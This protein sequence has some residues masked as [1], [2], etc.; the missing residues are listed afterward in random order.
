MGCDVSDIERVVQYLAPGNL[1]TLAQ[2]VGRA[3]R[4]PSMKGEGILLVHNPDG[5]NKDQAKD[6]DLNEFIKAKGCLRKILNLKFGDKHVPSSDLSKCCTNCRSQAHK[7]A[8]E[9]KFVKKEFSTARSTAEQKEQVWEDILHWRRM[10]FGRQR[11]T[12]LFFVD[13]HHILPDPSVVKLKEIF[14]KI[15]TIE[16]IHSQIKWTPLDNSWPGELLGRL[17]KLRETFKEALVTNVKGASTEQKGRKRPFGA[18][19]SQQLQQNTTQ[20]Q[21]KVT[22]QHRKE[23]KFVMWGEPRK[24]AR[25]NNKQNNE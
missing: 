7:A 19:S 5:R 18:E 12:K 9:L 20:H 24:K 4:D 8:P 1:I 22:T 17:L 13:E 2:R 23:M 16:D 6:K 14:D 10:T 3:A 25:Q 11:L 15:T 21:Q